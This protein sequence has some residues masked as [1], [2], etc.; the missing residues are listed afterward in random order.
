MG[1]HHH[2]NAWTPIE[3]QPSEEDQLMRAAGCVG[4]PG[5]AVAA[6]DGAQCEC[7]YVKITLR[8]KIV[9]IVIIIYATAAGLHYSITTTRT[10]A[11]A[12]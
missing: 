6:I 10:T 1:I 2:Y 4:E 3:Q 5:E 9:I 7:N 11:T 8:L 12:K